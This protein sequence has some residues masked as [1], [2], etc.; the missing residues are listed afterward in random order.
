M[1]LD[2]LEDYASADKTNL[3]QDILEFLQNDF[4]RIAILALLFI[5]ARAFIAL[6]VFS[7]ARSRNISTPYIYAAVVAA[8]GLIPLVIY[9]VIRNKAVDIGAVNED[10]KI[11]RSRANMRAVIAIVLFIGAFVY[12]ANLY[13]DMVKEIEGIWALAG[14]ENGLVISLVKMLISTVPDV[15]GGNVSCGDL[16]IE[17]A[18]TQIVSEI[19]IWLAP[20][21]NVLLAFALQ[22]DA[23]AQN[24]GHKISLVIFTLIFGWLSAAFYL[25]V[26]HKRKVR[27]V[28][29]NC[30]RKMDGG[31]LSI[32]NCG[33][34]LPIE[35]NA[36]SLAAQELKRQSKLLIYCYIASK[37]LMEAAKLASWYFGI[38]AVKDMVD[39]VFETL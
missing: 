8:G 5:A 7:D 20:A 29:S 17:T 24:R 21:A 30:G 34:M 23:K 38:G 31:P 18:Q 2:F 33:G 3:L 9:L 11:Q 10:A 4:Y 19:S 35:E 37:L 27:Y 16:K 22:R 26:R 28:C 36:H 1:K 14:S 6:A 32:C 12:G 25:C 15:I 39:R 13:T